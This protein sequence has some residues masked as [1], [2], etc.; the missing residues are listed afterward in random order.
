MFARAVLGGPEVAMERPLTLVIILAVLSGAVAFLGTLLGA[1]NHVDLRFFSQQA[2]NAARDGGWAT[3]ISLAR[4]AVRQEPRHQEALLFLAM[5]EERAG[6]AGRAAS[7]W[8]KLERVSRE[9]IERGNRAPQQ[10]HYLGWGL[11]G[12]GDHAGAR[13]AWRTLVQDMRINEDP[14][15]RVCFLALAGES[16]AALAAWEQWLE[17]PQPVDLLRWSRVDPDLDGI[18]SDPRF[19][20]AR[21]RAGDRRG[22]PRIQQPT[23]F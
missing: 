13:A 9:N 12:Q 22:T 7:V 5:A 4:P 3:V 1:P 8:S 14:Y 20:E 10:W 2:R 17:S 15:N 16:E 6:D 21:R 23:A 18:R 19:E 11:S